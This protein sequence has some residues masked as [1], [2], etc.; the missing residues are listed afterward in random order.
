M[1]EIIKMK[2]ID[3][4]KFVYLLPIVICLGFVIF[5]YE[6]SEAV[7]TERYN[8]LFSE[9]KEMVDLTAIEI[10]Q[11]VIKDNDWNHEREFYTDWLTYVAELINTQ[12]STIC[13]LM[14]KTHNILSN[15]GFYDDLNVHKV[16]MN[17]EFTVATNR[18]KSGVFQSSFNDREIS[19]YYK[20]IPNDQSDQLLLAVGV[21]PESPSEI[22]S[23][24]TLGEVGLVLFVLVVNYIMIG[25]IRK[26]AGDNYN[27]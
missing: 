9:K 13:I 25:K 23:I 10:N 17:Q 24:Y 16:F 22:N 1:K 7:K 15:P 12:P 6:F 20:W 19:I 11:F 4:T 14:D 3:F 26:N 21:I 18:N 5:F 2:K 27:G 8:L